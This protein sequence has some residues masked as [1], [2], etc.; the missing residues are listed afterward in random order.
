MTDPFP[1]RC[2]NALRPAVGNKP[3]QAKI[4]MPT[5]MKMEQACNDKYA[6]D[7]DALISE[8]DVGE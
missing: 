7:A 8:L 4:Q 2:L 6:V 5:N 3:G 1:S